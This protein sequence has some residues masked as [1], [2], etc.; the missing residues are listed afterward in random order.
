MASSR[1]GFK[2]I[3]SFG[4]SKR[5]TDGKP[6]TVLRISEN[7]L[8]KSCDNLQEPFVA[9]D[10]VAE[11]QDHISSS[12]V[13]S[14]ELPMQQSVSL[15]SGSASHVL[16]NLTEHITERASSP[17]SSDG[18]DDV[19]ANTVA[20]DKV[21]PA[22]HRG[23]FK[24]PRR[25]FKS[26]SSV[27]STS[28]SPA[29][30]EVLLSDSNV[31]SCTDE[32][33]LA[34]SQSTELTMSAVT[35]R[36]LDQP[37]VTSETSS[38]KT[39]VGSADTDSNSKDIDEKDSGTKSTSEN[40]RTRKIP[41]IDETPGGM[42]EGASQVTENWRERRPS[43]D[44]EEPRSNNSSN[45]PN[46]NWRERKVASSPDF[47][48]SASHRENWRSRKAMSV[49]ETTRD[50]NSTSIG[51]SKRFSTGDIQLERQD[52]NEKGLYL[53][54]K[55]VRHITFKSLRFSAIRM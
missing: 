44:L 32:S 19:F 4:E 13:D 49:D 24:K 53:F 52:S 1:N 14:T 20:K 17:F 18:S 6:I 35:K 46:E 38:I 15:N 51:Q 36:A 39:T 43:V 42:N 28:E 21:V 29:T 5:Q 34:S 12:S 25:P 30:R 40:W 16:Q 8:R 37:N 2:R 11:E 7:E 22:M 26:D 33:A 55:L 41:S 54:I 31:S 50:V 9:R 3:N 23:D 48:S 45:S 10:A 27:S 47:K